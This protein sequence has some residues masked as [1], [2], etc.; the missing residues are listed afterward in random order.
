MPIYENL[1]AAAGREEYGLGEDDAFS[2]LQ[3][4]VSSGDDASCLN[5]NRAQKPRLLGLDSMVLAERGSFNFMKTIEGV[6]DRSPWELLAEG[7]DKDGVV[8]GLIDLNTAMYALGKKLGD[9]VAY[10]DGRGEAFN[11]RLV[12]FVANSVLQGSVL[13]SEKTFIE[14]F[15]D[16]GG[17]KIFLLDAPSA[18]E[19]E[20]TV[21]TLSRMLED[22]GFAAMLAWERLAE[23][24]AVQNTYLSIFSTLGGL[25]V[26]LGTVGLAVLVGRN[27]LERKG[28]LGVMRAMG[29]TV[30]DLAKLVLAEH[31]FL[32]V[33]GVLLGLGTA[34]VAVSGVLTQRGG[35]L[36]VFMLLGIVVTILVAGLVFCWWAARLVLRFPLMEAIRSE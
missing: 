15:P 33:L 8:P 11:V 17:F 28:Q 24:N 20:R 31:W 25:G 4:R 29:F 19:G 21:K 14:K 6:D 18:A 9:V 16:A 26:L 30:R 27:V 2:I 23:F 3:I 22:R 12:G 5:L 7:E 1:N 13:I 35:E 10:E 34:L 36:P 32:H